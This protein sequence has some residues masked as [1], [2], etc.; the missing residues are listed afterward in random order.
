[1]QQNV[2][3]FLFQLCSIT[4]YDYT[5]IYLSI[6]LLT[7][8]GFQ[9]LDVINE[10]AMNIL[11]HVIWWTD[12]HFFWVLPKNE[13]DELQG[14]IMFSFSGYHQIGFQNGYINLH[15]YQQHMIVSCIPHHHQGL[16][17]SVFFVFNQFSRCKLVFNL[18]SL[19]INN[20]EHLFI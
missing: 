14:R 18:I 16:V 11:V 1:M 3:S 4:L 6:Q 8:M 10:A 15:P 5:L 9:F 20:V 2:F 13:T 12:T 19:M 17:L 7:D